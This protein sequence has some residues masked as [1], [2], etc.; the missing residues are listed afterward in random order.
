MTPGDLWHGPDMALVPDRPAP[1]FGTLA[2]R[3]PGDDREPV[4]AGHVR[5]RCPHREPRSFEQPARDGH[6]HAHVGRLRD[7][8][9]RHPDLRLNLIQYDDRIGVEIL[10][11]T[12]GFDFNERQVVDPGQYLKDKR[13]RGLGMF[14]IK[15]FVDEAEYE[16]NTEAGNCLR[17]IK[18]IH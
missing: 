17:L 15:R 1:R 5:R 18:R 12:Q 4:V 16:K 3:Q 6:P 8:P 10:D 11:R 13:E 14:I 9:L 7:V 2:A